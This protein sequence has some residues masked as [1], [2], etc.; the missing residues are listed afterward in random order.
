VTGTDKLTLVYGNLLVGS[1]KIFFTIRSK[2]YLTKIPPKVFSKKILA[3]Y[4]YFMLI[5]AHHVNV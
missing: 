3:T 1:A 5:K 4:Y 2:V